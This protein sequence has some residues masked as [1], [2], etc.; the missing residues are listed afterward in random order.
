LEKPDKASAGLRMPNKTKDNN[1]Q[2]ATMSERIFPQT[3]NVAV[4]I[5]MI[6]VST[7]GDM[8][9]KKVFLLD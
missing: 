6:R 3:K 7:S 5:K 1:E 4:R 9:N 8:K 2:R